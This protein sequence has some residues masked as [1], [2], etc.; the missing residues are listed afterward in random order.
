MNS[1]LF[2]SIFFGIL[3]AGVCLY[4]FIRCQETAE[5]RQLALQ[6]APKREIGFAAILDEQERG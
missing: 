3:A 6:D 2:F 5:Q 4:C 1:K